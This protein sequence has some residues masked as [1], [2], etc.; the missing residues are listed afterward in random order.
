MQVMLS[1]FVLA[2]FFAVL[3]IV[4]GQVHRLL[5]LYCIFLLVDIA[6]VKLRREEIGAA[7][8]SG[9]KFLRAAIPP[10]GGG[11]SSEQIERDRAVAELYGRALQVLRSYYFD[12]QHITRIIGTL[13]ATA[14]LCAAAYAVPRGA[15][16]LVALD[17]A[18]GTL[19][20]M[21][22]DVPLEHVPAKWNPVRRQGHAATL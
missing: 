9:Q 20:L 22:L 12:R 16:G 17:P 18:A 13:A 15:L 6:T 21:G 11:E 8:E 2:A 1:F 19:S 3:M 14:L 7:I 4:A 5:L 10:Q